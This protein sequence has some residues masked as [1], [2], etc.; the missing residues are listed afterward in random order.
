ME[1]EED[2]DSRMARELQA[3]FDAEL[4]LN[5][6]SNISNYSQEDED[7][8]LAQQLAMEFN[9]NF[10]DEALA[11][12][13]QN[14]SWGAPYQSSN[15]YGNFGGF[16][17]GSDLDLE[18]FLAG[19]ISQEDL[20]SLLDQMKSHI[21]PTLKEEALQLDLP[22]SEETIEIPKFGPVAFGYSGISLE[23]FEIPAAEMS[24]KLAGNDIHLECKKIEGKIKPFDWFFRQEN[25]PKLKDK[26]QAT[27]SISSTDINL[28]LRFNITASGTGLMVSKSEV[29]IGNLDIKV[30]KN[31]KSF[32]Y[33]IVISVAVRMLKPRLEQLLSDMLRSGVDKNSKELMGGI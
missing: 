18:K 25:F 17:L 10:D 12:Q 28:T 22:N 23:S 15:S 1:E 2:E 11:R 3:Q 29:K 24:L 32:I 5:G 26:G 6:N 31:A 4:N 9:E 33:N 20:D 27:A 19:N 30:A 7:A 21:I 16:D 13:L 8:R 14:Q